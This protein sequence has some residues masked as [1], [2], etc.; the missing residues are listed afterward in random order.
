MGS[1]HSRICTVAGQ[2]KE[3]INESES[4]T[5][6]AEDVLSFFKGAGSES[7]CSTLTN[8]FAHCVISVNLQLKIRTEQQFHSQTSTLFPIY[9]AVK[10]RPSPLQARM[11]HS[12]ASSQSKLSPKMIHHLASSLVNSPDPHQQERASC[13]HVLVNRTDNRKC[14]VT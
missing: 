8:Q 5:R 1:A 4:N 7:T 12:L 3:D 6:A 10:F 2:K 9:C 11:L 14:H 13:G